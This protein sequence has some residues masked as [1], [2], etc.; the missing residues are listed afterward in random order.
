MIV[1]FLLGLLGLV[2]GVLLIVPLTILFIWSCE[3]GNK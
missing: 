3:W 2:V 1:D